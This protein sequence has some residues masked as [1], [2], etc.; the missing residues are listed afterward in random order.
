[1]T[2]TYSNSLDAIE[3]FPVTLCHKNGVRL[4]SSPRF[5]DENTAR[6]W[7]KCHGSRA[8]KPRVRR[9]EPA[10]VFAAKMLLQNP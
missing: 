1:M 2:C 8:V 3:R 4:A 5:T 9:T 7:W 6:S 10:A